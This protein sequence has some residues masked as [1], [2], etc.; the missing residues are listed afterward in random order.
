MSGARGMVVGVAVFVFL[1]LGSRSILGP[2]TCRDGW[3]SPS[4]GRQGACSHHGGV[5]HS[6]MLL[7]FPFL[8]LAYWAGRLASCDSVGRKSDVSPTLTPRP[9]GPKCP[10]CMGRM[11]KL[12]DDDGPHA[13]GQYWRCLNWPVCKGRITIPKPKTPLPPPI[14]SDFELQSRKETLRAEIERVTGTRNKNGRSGY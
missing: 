8:G 5:S 12:T 9:P 6:R 14:L 1:V 7:I 2:A 11:S 4:I 10:S 13:G 3:R